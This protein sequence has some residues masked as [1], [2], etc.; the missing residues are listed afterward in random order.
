MGAWGGLRGIRLARVGRR[1][2]EFRD[3]ATCGLYS[4]E[5]LV[6]SELA[7][8]GLCFCALLSLHLYRPGHAI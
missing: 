4:P 1:N 2:L 5:L 8:R 7:C 3:L 6:L